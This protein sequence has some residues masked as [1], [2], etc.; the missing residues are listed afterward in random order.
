MVSSNQSL[1][2]I[3]AGP[4]LIR[5]VGYIITFANPS[6]V[7]YVGKNF[8]ESLN[9]NPDA[10]LRDPEASAFGHTFRTFRDCGI[11]TWGHPTAEW[12]ITYLLTEL[13]VT[14]HSIR[15]GFSTISY[16]QG[17]I[18]IASELVSTVVPG[19]PSCFS[20]IYFDV[21][22]MS[23]WVNGEYLGTSPTTSPTTRSREIALAIHRLRP[24]FESVAFSNSRSKDCNSAIEA[25]L[26]TIRKALRR[27]GHRT[28][29]LARRRA[30][31]GPT[32]VG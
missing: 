25:R 30:C 10:I 6:G 20:V 21:L 23:L 8:Q 19:K 11:S 29:C 14:P 1:A 32:G 31:H 26:E 15:H 13:A 9:G 5:M 28:E 24:N 18:D 27:F 4:R 3:Y 17:F 7:N 12:F 2:P 22:I 16:L